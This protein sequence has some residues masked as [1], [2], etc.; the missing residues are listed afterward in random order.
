MKILRTAAIALIGISLS[1][2]SAHAC[3]LDFS[4]FAWVYQIMHPQ[5][6]CDHHD[7]RGG[8]GR[9]CNHGGSGTTTPTAPTAPVSP[10]S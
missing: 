4:V 5:P 6:D 9:D 1:T 8:D 7:N 10:K 2:P 3:D